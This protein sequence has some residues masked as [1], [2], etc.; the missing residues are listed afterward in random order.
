MSLGSIITIVLA[1]VFGGALIAGIWNE[2]K[3][4]DFEDK[5]LIKIKQWLKNW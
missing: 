2:E 3:L 5:C 4:I 1:L